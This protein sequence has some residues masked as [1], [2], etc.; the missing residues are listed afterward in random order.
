M[1]RV[2]EGTI[3]LYATPEYGV[4]LCRNGQEISKDVLYEEAKTTLSKY[5]T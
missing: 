2:E 3:Q 5:S 4:V 1:D